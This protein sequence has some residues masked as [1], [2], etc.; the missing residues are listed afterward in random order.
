[1][2]AQAQH[3]A[4]AAD[5]RDRRPD[6]GPSARPAAASAAGPSARHARGSRAPARCRARRCRP[7]WRAGC[8]RRSCRAMPT[9]MPLAASAVARQAPIGKPPPMPLA[10]AMMSGVDARS[11]HGEQLAGAA[12]AGLHLVEDRGAGRARRRARASPA[13]TAAGRCGCR[14]RPGSAR[15]GSRA[16]SGVIGGLQRLVIAERHLVEALDLG[17]EAF[18]IFLLAAGRDGRQ[19]AAVEGALEGDDAEALGLAVRR[20]GICA[21]S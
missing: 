2:R 17:A 21:P 9:V 1:M 4:L 11:I 5:L 19:R 12:D 18:E 7:P 15:S 20:S 16:V 10:I 3:Q 8:R 6:G 14:P 13:G